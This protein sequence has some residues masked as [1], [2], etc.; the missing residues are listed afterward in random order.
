MKKVTGGWSSKG[1]G[2][3]T[4]CCGKA[5]LPAGSEL[6]ESGLRPCSGGYA[7]GTLLKQLGDQKLC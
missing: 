6:R 1:V 3:L 2:H 7:R 5:E 4:G